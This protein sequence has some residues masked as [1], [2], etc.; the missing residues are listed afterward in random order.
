MGRKPGKG[1]YERNSRELVVRGGFRCRLLDNSQELKEEVVLER[2][3]L[4]VKCDADYGKGSGFDPQ[5]IVKECAGS[6][7]GH[8]ATPPGIL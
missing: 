7:Y 8:E 2:N 3:L 5:G 6:N 4:F 1:L